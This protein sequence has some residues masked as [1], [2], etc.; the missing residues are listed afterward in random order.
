GRSQI[1][2]QRIEQDTAEPLISGPDDEAVPDLTPD[3]RW[4]LYWSSAPGEDSPTATKRLMRLPALG[5][6]PEQVLEARLDDYAYFDC[7]ARPASSCVLSHWEQGQLIFYALDPV[8]GRGKEV[9]RTKLGPSMRVDWRVSSNGSRIA[10]AS[11]DQLREQVRIIDFRNGTERN[12]QLPHG[13]LIWGL[14]WT[15]DGNAL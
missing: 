8:Q 4:I 7:P 14:S 15:S 9:T 1:F 6:S 10:V 2:K 12:L 13:W 3:G 5:G 11:L